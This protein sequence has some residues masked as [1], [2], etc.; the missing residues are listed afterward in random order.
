MNKTQLLDIAESILT[1]PT[2]PFHEDAVRAEIRRQLTGLDGVD[3]EQDDFGN[4][5]AR[6]QRGAGEPK[7]AFVA[8][9]D[10]PGYVGKEFLGGLPERYRQPRPPTVDYGAFSMLD[11]PAFDVR[12]GRI[13]SRACDDLIG[14]TAIVAAFHD[15][16]QSRRE[17]SCLGI[18]TRAEEIGFVGAIQLAK[19]RTLPE[20]IILI[21]LEASNQNAGTAKMG[22]GVILRV[23]DKTSIFDSV[24]TLQIASVAQG[25]DIPHQRSLMQG[26]SCEATA[27][28]VYG[29]RAAALCVAIGN[30][31]NQGEGD[32]VD[33][34]Y[35]SVDD[36]LGMALLCSALAQASDLPDPLQTLRD[37]F[38]Q[39]CEKY[40]PY[41]LN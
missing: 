17:G 26:G 38:D 25:R 11:L 28:Q 37:A 16:V 18:F 4:L 34:E 32:K 24:S 23:G 39:R 22:E 6:Y 9:M 8:H 1:Q 40:R 30:Y 10:H 41:F 19:S 29:Y 5:I 33:A 7:F 2:A 36:T 21:S 27:F 14:C 13:Y 20:N 35:V 15:L 12:D 31:H 3:V